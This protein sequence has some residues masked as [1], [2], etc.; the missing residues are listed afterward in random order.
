MAKTKNK[1]WLKWLGFIIAIPSLLFNFFLVSRPTSDY[2]IKVL[3]VLDGDT[4]LLDGKVRLRLRQVDSPELEYCYG[5]ESKDYLESLVKDKKITI[6]EK[7]LDQRGRAMAL[8]YLGKDLINLKIVANGFGRYHSDKTSQTENLKIAGNLAKKNQLGV[9]SPNCYQ[10]DKNLDNPDCIIKGNIDL[11]NQSL[12]RYYF[13]GC[14][15]YNSTIVEKDKDE[16]WFCTESEAQKAGY[17][18]AKSCYN[19]KFISPSNN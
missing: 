16:Q 13:P 2:G 8:V 11:N 6:Q 17:T 3:E 15:Q 14:A 9:Y 5:Q 7:I 1:S 12:K 18:K 19:Q 10:K 4:L